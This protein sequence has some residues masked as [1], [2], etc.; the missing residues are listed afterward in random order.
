MKQSVCLFIL[1]FENIVVNERMVYITLK[2]VY[3]SVFPHLDYYSNDQVVYNISIRM[4]DIRRIL[5]DMKDR[6][7]K[8]LLAYQTIY[9]IDMTLK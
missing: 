2:K 5:Q 9:V 6:E 4:P 8:N 1:C 7:Q 3:K